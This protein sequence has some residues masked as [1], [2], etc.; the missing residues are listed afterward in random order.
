VSA[1]AAPDVLPAMSRR[2]Q[3]VG[4]LRRSWLLLVLVAVFLTFGMP[5][6]LAGDAEPTGSNGGADIGKLCRD[7]GGTLASSV[8]SGTGTAQ[9]FCTVRYGGTVYRM[10][11]ITPAGFDADTAR[12]QRQGCVEAA[13]QQKGL[14]GSGSPQRTFV[15][16]PAT[17]VCEHR[18]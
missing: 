15:Y 12:F 3:L 7:H 16:H 6:W 2:R 18:P 8:G 4:V 17:G 11:A 13:R 9:R 5:R 10:D 14:T 1:D